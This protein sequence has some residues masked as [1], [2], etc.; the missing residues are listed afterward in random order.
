MM[1]FRRFFLERGAV[2]VLRIDGSC[3][4]VRRL[5]LSLVYPG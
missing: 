5:G 2:V 1:S 3:G 4:K